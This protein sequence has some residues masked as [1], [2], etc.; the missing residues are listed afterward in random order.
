MRATYVPQDPVEVHLVE[1]IAVA[2][3]R[4]LRADRV[5]ADVM[6]DIR[7]AF[8]GRSH[9]TNLVARDDARA[10]TATALRYRSQA[11]LE[12]Q[13]ATALLRR[14]RQ[15]RAAGLIPPRRRTGRGRPPR[16]KIARTNPTA[17]PADPPPPLSP[18]T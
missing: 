4:E 12:V 16:T 10:G 13:R 1:G 18:P 5:E 6:C 11:Q 2:Q 14:H 3:W 8:S 15:D 17:A 9:G 7:P